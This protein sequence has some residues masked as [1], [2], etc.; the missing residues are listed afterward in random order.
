MGLGDSIETTR[1]E[2]WQLSDGELLTRVIEVSRTIAELQA[3]RVAMMGEVEVRRVAVE[4]GYRDG[5]AWLAAHTL[6][7]IGEARAIVGLAGSLLRE[8]EIAD[9]V[10]AGEVS[11]RHAAIMCSFFENLPG[12]FP[13][14][15]DEPEAFAE[16][17]R[18]CREA[19]FLASGIRGTVGG[20]RRVKDTLDA[21][22]DTGEVRHSER[23]DL[24]RFD[25]SRTLNGRYA[26]RGDLDAESGEMLQAA[27][28]K[29]SAPRPADDGTR[30][31]RPPSQRRADALT[32]VV[33]RFLGAGLTGDEAGERPHLTVVIREQ[34]LRE[35]G[36]DLTSEGD[37]G[38]Y[39]DRGGG[40]GSG[41]DATR[42]AGG[43]DNGIRVPWTP[44]GG[45][46][47]IA[48][49]RKTACDSDVTPVV[50]DDVGVP[51]A[52]GRT[53]RLVT[54]SQR[55]ALRV[56]DRGCA[57]PGCGAPT[58]WTEAHHVVP[59][60]DGGP[61]DLDNLVLLCTHHHRF[62]HHSG[63]TVDIHDDDKMPWF[64]PPPTP[65][66]PSEPL[67]AHRNSIP[68]LA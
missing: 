53:T 45:T 56:R 2:P 68:L 50:V 25:L 40:A 57:F 43:R 30:D 47:S 54:Q 61:T 39:G 16:A 38:G 59:W 60:I 36:V 12:G 33:R 66:G 7:E 29:L 28:S 55:R 13:N 6:L 23:T 46:L 8:P 63:W 31:P 4:A 20:M 42:A 67:P 41:G 49:A 21:T 19:F 65:L 32:E 11:A 24:N 27:L 5:A 62:V 17:R 52:M 37:A 22:F 10:A 44:W 64:T 14:A 34:D 1:G 35:Q 48:A 26:L 3:R 51:L 9:A 15:V 58:G 18:E